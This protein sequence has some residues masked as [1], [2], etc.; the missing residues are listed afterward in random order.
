MNSVR[1][2]DSRKMRIR[3]AFRK[4]MKGRSADDLKLLEKE[5]AAVAE[6]LKPL[7]PLQTVLENEIKS[8]TEKEERS[9]P[10][11]KNGYWYHSLMAA[12]EKYPV[13]CRKKDEQGAEE[14]L[15]ADVNTLADN[16][17]YFD[18]D[19]FE[20]SPDNCIMAYAFDTKGEGNFTIRFSELSR[21]STLPD[22]LTNCDGSMAWSTD[23]SY[24]FY[25]TNAPG[26]LRPYCLMR[27]RM[28]D[29]PQN[30]SCLYRERDEAFSLSVGTAKSGEYIF[31]EIEGNNSTEVWYLPADKPLGSFTE[32]VSRKHHA[33][34][35]VEHAKQGFV[36]LTNKQADNYKIVLSK[37]RKYDELTNQE[38]IPESRDYFIDDFE[39]FSEFL[40]LKI[41]KNAAPGFL[42]YGFETEE[43]HSIA[44]DEEVFECHIADNELFESPVFRYEYSSFTTPD[45]IYDYD[46]RTGSKQLKYQ[47]KVNT[48]FLADNYVSRRLYA[49]SADGTKVPVSLVHHISLKTEGNNP[50]LLYGYGA[51]GETTDLSFGRALI[52]LIDRGFVYAVAHVRGGGELGKKWYEQGKMLS[53]KNSFKDFISCAEFLHKK[54]YSK[55]NL[56]FA[57]GESAGGLLVGAAANMRPDLFRAVIAEMPFVDVVSTM[58]NKKLPL[59]VGEY[60]EWGHPDNKEEYRYMLSYSPVD[61]V[62]AQA[63]PEMYIISAL[64]DS[65]VSYREALKWALKLRKKNTGP[66]PVLLRVDMNGGHFGASDR[67]G[68]IAETAGLYAFLIHRAEQEKAKDKI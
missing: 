8:R 54:G 47:K 66:H 39:V 55:P 2:T 60:S 58:K 25:I 33:E 14:S 32:F 51:Y 23:G 43:T 4:W 27:H 31:L 11:L 62:K 68:Q 65:R 38:L 52:S 3:H 7:M 45:S 26:T 53:K 29:N 34:F 5:N 35:F 15:I 21:N 28:G 17:E 16:E 1:N 24:F 44:F 6:H 42:I 59:T 36:V 41:R 50:L 30:D 12:D 67:P 18:F 40:V 56:T 22:E 46:L 63:Y 48:G 10:F 64:N 49:L 9:L 19:G 20:I 13:F 61:R 57:H 37:S